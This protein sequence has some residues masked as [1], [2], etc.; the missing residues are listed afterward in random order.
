MIKKRSTFLRSSGEILV[1]ENEIEVSVVIP[2]LNEELT[3]AGCVGKALRFFT[4]NRVSGEVIV[5]DNGSTDH[6]FQNAAAAGARVV[7]E[8][9]PG[10]GSAY[11]RGFKEARGKYLVM[12]DGDDT[13]DFSRLE[14]FLEPLKKGCDFVMG[15]R[16]KG[17]IQKGAMPWAN[18]YLG[19]PFLT[20]LYRLFFRTGLSDIHCGMRSFT[21]KAYQKLN[22]H[23]LG[24]EFASEM[25]M[26]ALLKK[27]KILE[28]PIDYSKRKGISKLS[29]VKDAW[30]HLRFMLL[31]CPTWLYMV[32][33][34]VLSGFG[35]LVMLLL[36]S[37]P[38]NFLGH[39]WD[40][41]MFILAAFLGVLGY[42]IIN[43][44]LYA[45][46]FAIKQGY[47]D[48]EPALHWFAKYFKLEIG[49][50]AGAALFFLGLALNTSIFVEWWQNSFGALYRIR[51]S[52][53]AMIFMILGLQTIFSSFFLSLLAI[54]R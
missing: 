17:K 51:E 33:G 1:G 8:S 49:L 2:C 25:V 41:H 28:V 37:G 11:L 22:L 7:V 46:L 52:V 30:R 36:M 6:S 48:E 21:Q 19:N 27:L 14:L 35:F 18:R 3:I 29:P 4:E 24:M 15:S 9:V 45:K 10:Y 42:Q 50:L 44:G 38:V 16:F 47:L 32:P 20:G 12:G 34:A 54:R 5:V 13:Y 23:C 31:F 43:T 53:A 40:I 26:E 39:A